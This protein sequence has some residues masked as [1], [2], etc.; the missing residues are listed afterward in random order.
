MAKSLPSLSSYLNMNNRHSALFGNDETVLDQVSTMVNHDGVIRVSSNH[1]KNKGF[2]TS[3]EDA[4]DSDAI[5][6]NGS[7]TNKF[8]SATQKYS[9]LPTYQKVQVSTY[10]RSHRFTYLLGSIFILIEGSYYSPYVLL[11]VN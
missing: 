4:Q 6:P 9:M 3:V 7:K 11:C 2:F 8:K 5:I 10:K 1:K